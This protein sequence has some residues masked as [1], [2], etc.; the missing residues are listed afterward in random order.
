VARVP[1]RVGP[2]VSTF[3]L[4]MSD[5]HS[6]W[7]SS[8]LT[9]ANTSSGL[10]AISIVW[11]IFAM[12]EILRDRSRDGGERLRVLERGEVARIGPERGRAYGSADDLRRAR[13]RQRL[14]EDDPLRLERPAELARHRLGDL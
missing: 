3:V 13:L 11:V 5:C 8:W 10:R 1:T 9:Y 12:R 6:P 4:T 7:R 14:D 2:S